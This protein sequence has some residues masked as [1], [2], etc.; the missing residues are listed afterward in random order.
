MIPGLI[1][2]D[3]LSIEWILPPPLSSGEQQR[4]CLAVRLRV[5]AKG[6][7]AALLGLRGDAIIVII[8]ISS[9]NHSN[10]IHDMINDDGSSI[11]L[12]MLGG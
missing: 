2:R 9:S 10:H 3:I 4:G 1:Y 12:A 6:H 5:R 11:V 7:R 8:I